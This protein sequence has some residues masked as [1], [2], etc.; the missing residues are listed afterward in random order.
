MARA[1]SILLTLAL[2]LLLASGCRIA[3]PPAE[4]LLTLYVDSQVV[5]CTGVGPQQCLRVRESPTAAWINF[6]GGIEGFTH[7]PGYRY[8]LLVSRRWIRNPPADGSSAEYRLIR[9]V[10][11]E[12]VPPA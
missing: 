4:E 3:N 5:E 10:S 6:H 8:E 11:R 9:I 1:T 12:P 7:E 2:T